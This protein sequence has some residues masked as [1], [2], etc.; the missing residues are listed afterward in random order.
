[1]MNQIS[2]SIKQRLSLRAPLQDSL[3]VIAD[4]T[5]R[6]SLTKPSA[7]AAENKEF[8]QQELAVIKEAYP[9]LKDFQREFPSLAFSIAT[10]VGKTR[11]MGA[12]ISYLYLAKGIKNFFILSP[13]LTIYEKL[14]RDFGDP[15][16]AKYVFNG[17]S[18]FVHNRPVIITGDNYNQQSNLFEESEIRINI[19]N[20]SKF[21]SDNKGT[22]KA[23]VSLAPKIKRLSEYLGQSYWEYLT[24]I[25]DLVILMDEAHRYHADASKSAINELKPILG[26]ELTAT[27]TDEKGEV[28]KNIIYEYNLAQALADG[29][30]VKNPAI[31]KRKNF[32][33]GSLSDREV[34]I[35]KLEDAV[36]VHKQTRTE[37][38][39]Y[40]KTN[41]VKQVKPFILV[42]CK[43][44]T[45][46]KEIYELI[47]SSE[48]YGGEYAG[49]VL[50]IDSSTKKEEE[51]EK[52]FVSLEELDN[53]I[54]IVIHVNMLKEGWDVS[55]LCT[56]VPLRAANAKILIEQTIGRGLRLP[57][58]GKRTGVESVDKLTVIAHD[59]FNQIIEEAQKPDSILNKF[60]FIEM[61]EEDL[62]I[63]TVVVTAKT[64]TE[65]Q[66][67][68]EQKKVDKIESPKSKQTAQNVLDAKKAVLTA[69][70]K[71][72]SSHHVKK[73]DDLNKEEVKEQVL[74]A[75]EEN[76]N[77][78]Q[79]NM[80]TEQIV[81]EARA[82]YGEII[83]AYKENIIE[84]PRMD[85][86][87]GEVI[88]TFKDFDLDTAEMNY[89]AL[90]NEIIRLGIVDRKT[91]TIGVSSSGSYGNPVK[92]IISELL[93]YS[94]VDYDDNAELLHKLATQAYS[95]LEINLEDKKEIA[96]TVFQFKTAIAEKIYMQMRANFDLQSTDYL[97]PKIL[98]FTK[99]E[100]HNFT[101]FA[102]DGFRDYRDVITPLSL[103]LKFV[104]RGFEKACHFE[105]KFDSNT[106]KDFAIILEN[107][108]KVDKWMRPAANQFRLWWSNNSKKYEPD[109]VVE[110]ADTIYL[111][112]PKEAGKMTDPDVQD[113]RNA[114]VK[115]CRYATQYS[116]ENGGK[117]WK[118]ALVP[119]DKITITTG[120][121][122]LMA[123]YAL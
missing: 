67:E 55:N 87:Q 95:A 109:F 42:V 17:I 25:E 36:S 61:D 1:M 105:Y 7:D 84:I 22:K 83:N 30:F 92:N 110:T 28:F 120:F 13:N 103:V 111:V 4:V 72:N 12:I 71:F 98:P 26:V 77:T 21:N 18:E 90:E 112:E 9:A 75:I 50:Q 11:L 14:I 54:E 58:D 85:L 106:E 29:T 81:T 51:I 8:L 46:A 79:L 118:Y 27:P 97:E 43:D 45:H 60:S 80:F 19:F 113:K 100:Q 63:K 23:G 24:G 101:A 117:P 122:F 15:S 114:A 116:A 37:L 99:I 115:F 57:Y 74:K 96:K 62:K 108:D 53:E 102:S 86:V 121:D 104:F 94:D 40:S 38:E 76:L 10:G 52:L 119:H 89:R 78:G 35:I 65:V 3:D 31:A 39:L 73:L 41:E 49:K 70:P 59:N 6:L 48:F 68:E 82:N 47:S 44:I 16:Y 33:R 69:I 88:A 64:N 34:D 56:I 66:I 107:D 91:E 2:A 93:N 32:V 20:I 123:Q 5:N